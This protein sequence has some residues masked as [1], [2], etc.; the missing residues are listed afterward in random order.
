MRATTN[1]ETLGTAGNRHSSC[2][3]C[4]DCNPSSLWL[5]FTAAEDGSVKAG[6][7][8]WEELQGYDDILH[9]GVIA[10][11]LDSAMTHCLFHQGIQAVTGDLHVRFVHPVGCEVFL[12]IQARVLSSHPPLFRLRAELTVDGHLMAWAEGKFMKRD[13]TLAEAAVSNGASGLDRSLE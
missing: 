7:K 10:A 4:G 6:F 2:L 8:A 3:L 9:G 13:E 1:A 11:L 5:K 12:E